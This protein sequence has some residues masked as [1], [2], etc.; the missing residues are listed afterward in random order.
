[1]NK[2]NNTDL[3]FDFIKSKQETSYSEIIKNFTEINEST[4]VRN[5]NKLAIE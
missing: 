1:M 5:L 3:I 2:K 4:I